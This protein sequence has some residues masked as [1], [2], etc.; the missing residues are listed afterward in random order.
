MAQQITPRS[1]GTDEIPNKRRRATPA[2]GWKKAEEVR[3][4]CFG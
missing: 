1:Y 3:S 2:D 4:Q